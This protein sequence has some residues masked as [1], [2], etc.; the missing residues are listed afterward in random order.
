MSDS[1]TIKMTTVQYKNT[2]SSTTGANDRSG[3]NVIKKRF[4]IYLSDTKAEVSYICNMLH[5]PYKGWP[6]IPDTSAVS[7]TFYHIMLMILYNRAY[8]N[9][10]TSFGVLPSDIPYE[11]SRQV[12]KMVIGEGG[13]YLKK[14]TAET[15]VDFIWVDFGTNI[16]MVWGENHKC[17]Y[18]ALSAIKWRINKYRKIVETASSDLLSNTNTNTN[19]E[20]ITDKP[21]VSA[22]SVEYIRPPTG[23]YS[24]NSDDSF[25]HVA[26]TDV[27]EYTAVCQV[28]GECELNPIWTKN[29]SNESESEVLVDSDVPIVINDHESGTDAGN[30]RGDGE[31]MS[32]LMSMLMNLISANSSK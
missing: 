14:T 8:F 7:N 13:F 5:I 1:N 10:P 27:N 29:D 9:A 15:G 22:D 20:T 24:E 3:N 19:A 2:E 23:F 18:N 30:M 21:A 11:I 25:V 32:G 4:D 17:V 6:Y 26:K 12:T 31:D 16:F 28:N